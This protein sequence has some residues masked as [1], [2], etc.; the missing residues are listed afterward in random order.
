[1]TMETLNQIS[2]D[3]FRAEDGRTMA[4]EHGS[5]P[6]GNPLSGR[7]VL[8]TADGAFLDF[9]QYRHDLAERNGL[10]FHY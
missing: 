5:T 9:D 2:Q 7:W 1:M 10:R 8:R 4:R 3:Q 6:N